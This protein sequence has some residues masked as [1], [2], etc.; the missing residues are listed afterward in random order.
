MHSGLRDSATQAAVDEHLN[1]VNAP[2]IEY[3]D[4]QNKLET[5]G[6]AYSVSATLG[7]TPGFSGGVGR[8]N[9]HDT[10]VSRAGISGVGG[11]DGAR[12]GDASTSLKNDFDASKA[13]AKLA[14]QV[15][16]TQ[17]L[18][19]EAPQAVANFA[20]AQM[21][22]AQQQYEAAGKETDPQVRE[23]KEQ[24][25]KD[26]LAAWDEGG[27]YRVAMH[28]AMGAAGAGWQGAIGAGASASAAKY[29]DKL[30]DSMRSEL[31][32]T[33]GLGD[34]AAA[35]VSQGLIQLTTGAAGAT[36]GGVQGA[37]WA[38][39]V[40]VNNRQLHPKEVRFLQDIERVK[41]YANYMQEK[42]G[43]GLSVEEASRNLDRYGA[44]MTDSGSG[45]RSMAGM[46][47]RRRSSRLRPK[48]PN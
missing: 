37:Q 35:F 46:P 15:S 28:V 34:T 23:Q 20:K 48:A 47:I 42:T 17:T 22:Q 19:K 12:K 25:A 3:A 24:D 8:I 4:V 26:R 7:S 2:S 21:M 11:Q 40:D 43:R 13:Q 27:R 16:I 39:A 5:K 32:R 44:A 14:A 33:L 30:Q 18:S 10:S 29:M 1:V 41:R 36:L 6:Q 31:S 9:D 45:A 38:T